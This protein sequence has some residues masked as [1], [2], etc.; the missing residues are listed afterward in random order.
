M[1]QLEEMYSYLGVLDTQ[2]YRK[3]WKDHYS[4]LNKH[5]FNHEKIKNEKCLEV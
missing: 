2:E 5:Y 1:E 3:K 4:K